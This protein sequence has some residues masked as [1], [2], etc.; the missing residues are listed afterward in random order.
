MLSV[1]GLA[2]YHAQACEVKLSLFTAMLST[3][4][5]GKDLPKN[6]SDSK[7]TLD[8]KTLGR[9]VKV[10]NELVTLPE[11]FQADLDALVD[12]RNHLVHH[13]F[14][15]HVEDEFSARGRE[16]MCDELHEHAAFFASIARTLEGM[17]EDVI[18]AVAALK[19]TPP[20]VIDKAIEDEMR[21]RRQA[22]HERDR[23][24][25]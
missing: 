10:L 25:A 14:R 23:D 13:F 6:F 5:P 24:D 1:Y 7:A 15:D 18:K 19:G 20:E 2:A 4:G 22:G 16:S 17:T 9:V 21:K 3:T 12:K 8:K 11:G